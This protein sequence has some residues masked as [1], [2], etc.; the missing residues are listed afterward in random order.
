MTKDEAL[1]LRRIQLWNWILLVLLA[2]GSL[3]WF[4]TSV[5]KGVLVGGL[6]ANS[7][8]WLLRRDLSRLLAGELAAVKVRFFLKYYARLTLLAVLLFIL[9]KYDLLNIPGLL[10]GLSVVFLSIAGVAVSAA[11]KTFKIR[12]AS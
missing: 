1:P 4:G 9:I 2:G 12:E 11:I 3:A 6:L 7:S 5:A 10:A 8:F